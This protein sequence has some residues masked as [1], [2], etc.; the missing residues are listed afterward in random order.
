MHKKPREYGQ[1]TR[2]NDFFTGQKMNII[3]N[4]TVHV[5]GKHKICFYLVGN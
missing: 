5:K 3:L 2:I 1:S 4:R